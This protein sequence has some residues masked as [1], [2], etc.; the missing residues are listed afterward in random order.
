MHPI[1]PKRLLSMAVSRFRSY[2]AEAREGSATEKSRH[3][4]LQPLVDPVEE[5]GGREPPLVG[6]DEEGEVLG[7][8]AGFD[9]VDADLLEGGREPREIVVA[10]ELGAV[11]RWIRQPDTGDRFD[12]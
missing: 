2:R 9:G 1:G 7:H 11:G 5:A 8:E 4:L 6:A 12:P 3:R 10:V